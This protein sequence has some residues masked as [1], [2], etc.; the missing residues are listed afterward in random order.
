MSKLLKDST[1]QAILTALRTRDTKLEGILGTIAQKI[2]SGTGGS[3]SDGVTLL[4]HDK[5]L[6]VVE[7]AIAQ[8]LLSLEDINQYPDYMNFIMENFND[9]NQIDMT[10]CQVTAISGRTLTVNNLYGI[11]PYC[12]Y[13]ISDGVRSETVQI[14]SIIRENGVNLITLANALQNV[15]NSGS[16]NLYR[17]SASVQTGYAV[18]SGVSGSSTW[19]ADINWQGIAGSSEFTVSAMP[20]N[21]EI[22]NY[23]LN[24]FALTSTGYFVLKD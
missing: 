9:T 22:G 2:L 18:C 21:S 6:E 14:Y 17:S 15:Y 7:N 23:S 4:N 12:D 16:V 10:Q 24:S 3:A 1:A 13:I 19:D 5:R 11:L 8:I 20:S